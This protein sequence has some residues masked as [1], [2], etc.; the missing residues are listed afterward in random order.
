MSDTEKIIFVYNAKSGFMHSMSDL[1][2]KTAKPSEYPC[3]LCA[4]TYNGAFMKKVWKEYVA[5]LGI[6]PVFL[7]KDQFSRTYPGNDTTFPTIL[8]AKDN[9][10]A[11]LVSS[12]DFEQMK[13]VTD[14]MKVLKERLDANK[15]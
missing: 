10:V 8:L 13:D 5:N 14:L 12:S 7:H 3:K 1:F 6:N 11:S 9:S 2:T 4:L 15:G